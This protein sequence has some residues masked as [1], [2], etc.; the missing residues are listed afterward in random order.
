VATASVE[1]SEA[2]RWPVSVKAL[3]ALV[4]RDESVI[5]AVLTH[6][7]EMDLLCSEIDDRCFMLLALQQPMASDLRFLVAGI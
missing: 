7:E 6:E 5:Q 1:R 2:A 3:K 4:D